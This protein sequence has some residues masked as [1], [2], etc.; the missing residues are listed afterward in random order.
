M[1]IEHHFS[2]PTYPQGNGQAEANNKTI[3]MT[4]KKK[5]ESS[6]AQW[7]EELS[8][9]LWAYRVTLHDATKETPYSLAYGVEVVVIVEI[10]LPSLQVQA[11]H[12]KTNHEALYEAITLLKEKREMA[13]IQVAAYQQGVARNY[14]QKVR[15][16]LIN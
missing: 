10:G 3:I 9:V 15:Y 11:Y 5:L 4:L 6:K 2:T 7:V 14:N 1:R 12:N 8:V 16:R 13:T